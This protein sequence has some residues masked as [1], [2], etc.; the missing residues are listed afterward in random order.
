MSSM[1][2]S[3][4]KRERGNPNLRANTVTIST[5]AESAALRI[6]A[7]TG[8]GKQTAKSVV[9]RPFVHTADKS[10]GAWTAVGQVFAST[11]N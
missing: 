1:T 11:G 3:L 2:I 9:D 7:F 6:F 8:H 5:S 4:R 10:L